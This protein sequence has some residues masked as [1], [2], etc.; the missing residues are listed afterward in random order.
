[1]MHI[2]HYRMVVRNRKMRND[3]RDEIKGNAK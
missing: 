1:M 2:E 3:E